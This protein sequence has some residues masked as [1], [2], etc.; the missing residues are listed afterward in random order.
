MF[1]GSPQVDLTASGGTLANDP[2]FQTQLA[3]EEQTLQDDIN[4]YEIY[5]VVQA[6]L[7]FSF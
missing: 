5:P 3:L 2:N 1:T 6:G 4:D 7:T